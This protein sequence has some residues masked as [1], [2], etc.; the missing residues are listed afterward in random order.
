M[1][2][3]LFTPD[4]I[5]DVCEKGLV[6]S[7]DELHNYL[8]E[9]LHYLKSLGGEAPQDPDDEESEIEENDAQ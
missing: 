3:E 7:P 8:D 5:K 6:Y 2:N 1:Q 9:V 4:F